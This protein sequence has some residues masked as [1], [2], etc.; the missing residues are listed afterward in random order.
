[1]TEEFSTSYRKTKIPEYLE[2][3][4][5]IKELLELSPSLTSSCTTKQ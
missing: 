3:S 1:L 5:T 2:Q 4:G